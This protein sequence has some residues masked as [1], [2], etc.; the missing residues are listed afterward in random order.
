LPHDRQIFSP[1]ELGSGPLGTSGSVGA[2][3][4]ATAVV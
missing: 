2:G 3:T 1:D 4:G